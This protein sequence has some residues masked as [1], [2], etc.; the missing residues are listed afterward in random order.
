MNTPD[1]NPLKEALLG[2]NLIAQARPESAKRFNPG[3]LA[4]GARFGGL[5]IVQPVAEGPT[6]FVYLAHDASL[7]RQVIV[8]EYFPAGIAVRREGLRIAVH[9]PSL[10]PAFDAGLEAFLNEAEVL[11]ASHSPFLAKVQRAWKAHGTAYQ[12]TPL[13]KAVTLRQAIDEYL[14][15]PSQ[16]WVREVL[17]DLLAARESISRRHRAPIHFGPD[18]ILLLEDG[19]PLLLGFGAARQALGRQAPGFAPPEQYPSQAAMR[20]G[21]WSDVYTFAANAYYLISART[22]LPALERLEKDAQM[23]AR[24]AGKDRYSPALL[25]ALDRALA[26]APERRIGSLAEFRQALGIP[27]AAPRGM[28]MN[29]PPVMTGQDTPAP[30]PVRP[31]PFVSEPAAGAQTQTANEENPRRRSEPSLGPVASPYGLHA[32]HRI[33]PV[34]TPVTDAAATPAPLQ[35][36]PSSRAIAPSRRHVRA[37]GR[38]R[39]KP[40]VA[41]LAVVLGAGAVAGVYFGTGGLHP[42]T[43]GSGRTVVLGK[44]IENGDATIAAGQSERPAVTSAPATLEKKARAII[45]GIRKD[46][47]SAAAKPAPSGA[48][49][50]NAPI[51]KAAPLP[52]ATGPGLEQPQQAKALADAS[53][54]ETLWKTATT[55]DKPPAYQAYLAQYPAGRYASLARDKLATARLAQQNPA[56]AADNA[57]LAAQAAVAPAGTVQTASLPSGSPGSF[58]ATAQPAAAATATSDSRTVATA[59]EAAAGAA[60]VVDLSTPRQQLAM[61]TPESAAPTAPASAGQAS[62]SSGARL[63]RLDGQTLQGNFNTDER[64]GLVSGNGRITWSNG[65]RYEGTL[66]R[67]VKQGKGEFIWSNGLRYSGDWSNDMPNGSG[68][69]VFP[70]GNRYEGEI[71]DGKPNGKGT[72]QFANGNKYEGEVVDGLPHGQGV[73]RFRSG[74]VYAGAWSRGRIQGNGRYTW[75]SG[76]SWEGEFRDDQRTANG[77]M[78]SADENASLQASG[79]S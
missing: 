32:G 24:E 38:R 39:L 30:Q 70:N 40:V 6:S 56:G 67:G 35:P 27:G 58:P 5:E 66:V 34:L 26:V 13:Y 77:R 43:D 48:Q 41:T 62:A 18:D 59:P 9:A 47:A 75:A 16:E 25:A 68:T 17:A 74:D 44:P 20:N 1:R 4:R 14:V 8:K 79:G 21:E 23:S 73:H 61:R 78:L 12:V 60:P 22:P 28:P 71:R 49:P 55:I 11:A 3:M 69:M 57:P 2:K 37:S 51:A 50:T 36:P 64:T 53:S 54:D 15:V 42:D 72:L 10:E 52:A 46:E 29:L 76:N 31:S 65:N 19:R 33:E 45:A 63:I 7:Q